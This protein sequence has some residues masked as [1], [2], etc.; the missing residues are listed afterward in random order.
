MLKSGSTILFQGDSITDA[1]RNRDDSNANSIQALGLGYAKM[2]PAQL[3]AERPADG[4]KFYN[5]GIGGTGSWIFTR[6][7][8]RT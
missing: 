6:A 5:R 1:G 4:L 3:L 8:N 2:A 7:S